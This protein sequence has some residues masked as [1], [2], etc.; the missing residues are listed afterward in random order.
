MAKLV[1]KLRALGH[2]P[3]HLPVKGGPCVL[4]IIAEAQRILLQTKTVV[5]EER[6]LMLSQ[7]EKQRIKRILPTSAAGLTTLYKK[8]LKDNPHLKISFSEF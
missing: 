2:L 1:L 7:V 8:A 6:G 5:S 4:G 3:V